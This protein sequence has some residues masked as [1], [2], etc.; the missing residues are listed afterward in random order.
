MS[1]WTDSIIL[2]SADEIDRMRHAGRIVSGCLDLAGKL[3]KPGATTGEVDRQVEEYIRSEV[4]VPFGIINRTRCT[5]LDLRSPDWNVITF[6][7]CTRL[8][9]Q[10]VCCCVGWRRRVDLMTPRFCFLGI[11]DLGPADRNLSGP[12][13]YP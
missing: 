6:N 10:L 9:R 4:M 12:K 13:T 3:L 5:T 2:K 1:A 7:A 8:M 11:I